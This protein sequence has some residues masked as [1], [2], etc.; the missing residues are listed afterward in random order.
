MVI[1]TLWRGNSMLS[2]RAGS[3]ISRWPIVRQW[4]APA[5]RFH[6]FG[7]GSAKSGTH[8][9]AAIFQNSYSSAHEAEHAKMIS[10]ILQRSERSLPDAAVRRWLLRRDRRLGLEL[11]SSQ[12]NASFA[13]LLPDLFP[14]ARFIL[15]IRDCYSFLESVIDH[16]LSRPDSPDWR[17][18]RALR[19]G[20]FEYQPQEQAL[21]RRGLYPLAGY[22]SYWARHNQHVLDCIPSE[23]LLVVRT[24]EIADS[25]HQIAHFLEIDPESIDITQCHA[26]PAKQ[27][28]GVLSQIDHDFIEHQVATYCSSI[29]NQ[30]F[31]QVCGAAQFAAA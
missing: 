2:P 11:D 22:L 21:I 18:M 4:R 28:F 25:I 29:M 17:Q 16:Q 8:S 15:T 9:I 20:G 31:P 14:E 30:F 10:A 5:R 7:L 26:Y 24:T 23:R 12:L 1:G 27:R 3:R 19:F 13:D 6:A